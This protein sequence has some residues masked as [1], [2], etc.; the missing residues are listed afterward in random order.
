M[1]GKKLQNNDKMQQKEENKQRLTPN[2]I[3]R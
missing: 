3:I 2:S 1:E